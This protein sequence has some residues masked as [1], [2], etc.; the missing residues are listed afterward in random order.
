MLLVQGASIYERNGEYYVY[1]EEVQKCPACG[2]IL[3]YR[4]TKK[5]KV[6]DVEGCVCIYHLRRLKCVACGVQHTE[7]PSTI[8]PHRQY[9]KAVI[10]NAVR[11]LPDG[12]GA[13]TSTIN[14]WKKAY[15]VQDEIGK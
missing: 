12:C 6:I 7:F 4:D 11:G 14:R 13:E 5:R 15:S 2:G 9:S 10:E 1:V 8:I 3:K